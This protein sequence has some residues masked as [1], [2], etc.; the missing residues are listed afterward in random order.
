MPR[1]PQGVLVGL[2]AVEVVVGGVGQGCARITREQVIR[3]IG[4]LCWK[5]EGN[6]ENRGFWGAYQD[7]WLC[8]AAF[9]AGNGGG[10]LALALLDTL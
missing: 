7:G 9:G 4:G 6:L 1:L 10:V 5:W 2:R 3:G 8:T